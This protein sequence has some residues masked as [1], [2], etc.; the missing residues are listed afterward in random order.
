M[1]PER[2]VVPWHGIDAPEST[3]PF[4]QTARTF[5]RVLLLDRRVE[6]GGGVDV[7]GRLVARV[8]VEGNDSSCAVIGAGLA[9]TFHRYASDP[10][11]Q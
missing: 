7:Y 2:M 4:G 6:G 5:T 10:G 8:F 3:E 1:P 11:S 9:C